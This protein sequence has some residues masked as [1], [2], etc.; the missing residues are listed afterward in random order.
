[1]NGHKADTK[2][3]IGGHI[4]N[5]QDKPVTAQATSHMIRAAVPELLKP[6]DLQAIEK[7]SRCWSRRSDIAVRHVEVKMFWWR[8]ATHVRMLCSRFDL[9]ERLGPV[10]CSW[11]KRRDNGSENDR[12]R[13]RRLHVTR[14]K[15]AYWPSLQLPPPSS[16]DNPPVSPF[17]HEE[18]YCYILLGTTNAKVYDGSLRNARPLTS[19]GSVFPL[20]AATVATGSAMIL[21]NLSHG[22]SYGHCADVE[23]G[24]I[25]TVGECRPLSKTVRFN[26]LK[27]SKD[28]NVLTF[29]ENEAKAL[30]LSIPKEKAQLW[31]VQCTRLKWKL[32]DRHDGGSFVTPDEKRERSCIFHFDD[33]F[34]QAVLCRTGYN[35]NS[36][37]PHPE[38][39]LPASATE[40]EGWWNCRPATFGC[41]YKTE[42]PRIHGSSNLQRDRM[43]SVGSLEKERHATYT[44]EGSLREKDGL[45]NLFVDKVPVVVPVKECSGYCFTLF[46]E[47]TVCVADMFGPYGER[48]HSVADNPDEWGMLVY[49]HINIYG[50]HVCILE[51]GTQMSPSVPGS[52]QCPRHRMKA[53]VPKVEG[54]HLQQLRFSV[55]L[56]IPDTMGRPGGTNIYGELWHIF[57]LCLLISHGNASVESGFS[58]N[59]AI[60]VESLVAQRHVLDAIRY[61]GGVELIPIDQKM[62]LSVKYSHK[63]YVQ[64]LE[65][66]KKK[67]FLLQKKKHNEKQKISEAMQ[68][69]EDEKKK[70]RLEAKVV[71]KIENL[72]DLAKGAISRSQV[73]QRDENDINKGPHSQAAEAE[74]LAQPFL[75]VAQVHLGFVASLMLS[76][77]LL[78]QLRK[79]NMRNLLLHQPVMYLGDIVGG[80]RNAL[81]EGGKKHKFS[82]MTSLADLEGRQRRDALPALSSGIQWYL[83]P[84]AYSFC[85]PVNNTILLSSTIYG[86]VNNDKTPLSQQ[87]YVLTDELKSCMPIVAQAS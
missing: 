61:F 67:S 47:I 4:N 35:F 48:T 58:V 71:E 79:F 28:C 22:D 87:Q 74:E 60:L 26:V 14:T 75:P 36:L 2:Q 72:N 24:D 10:Q 65:D 52:G 27:V 6:Y 34:N 39:Y 18:I 73:V 53:A 57:K 64:H 78:V 40:T 29:I 1:M 66:K 37:F 77:L 12:L 56:P 25:V 63:R 17:W 23:I 62:L 45:L 19:S 8:C 21:A 15:N 11:Q 41:Y 69:L 68:K 7:N 50:D 49:T 82:G 55:G 16:T 3:A 31:L 80:R 32:E 81:S 13:Q 54:G 76:L 84:S 46:V 42:G 5:L 30:G 9:G 44:T 85:G 51:N 83:M 20:T 86:H 43:P 70:I 38:Y 59:K 33:D